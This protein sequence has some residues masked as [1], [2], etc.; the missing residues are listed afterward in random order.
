MGNKLFGIDIAKIVNDSI[1]GAG[2]VLL[3]TLTRAT[4]GTRTPGNLT[5][6]TNPSDVTYPFKGFV[7]TAGERRPGSTSSSSISTVSILGDSITIEP[8]VNDTA[9][10]E[11]ED[12]T[13]LELVSRDPAK[14]LYVFKAEVN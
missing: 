13:L 7:E 6:G 4:T 11:G 14:A 3:G 5:G 8:K 10:I 2:G 12:W 9:T 1:A